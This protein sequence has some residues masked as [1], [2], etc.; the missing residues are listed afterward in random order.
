V[1][2]AD[3]TRPLIEVI[4]QTIEDARAAA[5][6]GA[7]RLEVVRAIGVGGL[8]PSLSVVDAIK[9][10][11]P[12]PLRVMVREDAGFETSDAELEILRAAAWNFAK[13]AV[14]GLVVGFAK[15]GELSL[16]EFA[17]VIEAAPAVPITFHRAFDSLHDQLG[18]I[19]TLSAIRRVD[20]ILTSGGGGNAS[21]RC[22]RLEQFV[23][24][25]GSRLSIIAG[26]GVDLETFELLARNQTV[27]WIHVGRVAREGN[28]PEGPVSAASVR[29][30]RDLADG[31]GRSSASQRRDP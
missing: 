26:G 15:S 2:K 17:S 18:A 23:E 28:D 9:R 20:G 14:D 27:R 16:A 10:V 4:V 29:R 12:L 3:A 22:A 5:E 8:T 7:D 6:G 1:R 19:D 24:R 21:E 25:A 30:L 31:V 11:T 13:L